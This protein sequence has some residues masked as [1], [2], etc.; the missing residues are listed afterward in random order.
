MPNTM[1]ECYNNPET[2][3]HSAHSYK[4]DTCGKPTMTTLIEPI[5]KKSLDQTKHMYMP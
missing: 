1:S 4:S 2:L 5:T 3:L